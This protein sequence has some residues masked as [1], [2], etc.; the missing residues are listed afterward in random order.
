MKIEII[1]IHNINNFGSVF[2]TYGLY[3]YL[4]DQGHDTEVIDYN[5]PYFRH[6]NLKR[7]LGEL[8]FFQDYHVR[9]T[10]FNHF[11]KKNYKLSLKNYKTSKALQDHPPVADLYVAGG[12]QLWNPYHPCGNDDMYK[13][14]FTNGKKISYGTSMGKSSFSDNELCDLAFKI[15]DYFC[16]SVRESSSVSL[17]NKVGIQAHHVVDPV[18]LL[19]RAAYERYV[20][21][22]LI[23]GKYMFVYLV[24][25]SKLLEST[26]AYI[27]KKMGLKVVLCA[28]LSQKSTCDYMLRN[29]GPEEILSY[30]VNAEFIISASFH[31]T[32]FS[33]LYHK[34]FATLL[35]G[36][37]TN[38]RIEDFLSWNRLS[39]RIIKSGEDLNETLFSPVDFVFADK[40]IEAKRQYSLAYI[41]HALDTEDKKG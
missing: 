40:A 14:S 7:K 21:K 15:K 1:T 36:S 3:K 30:I 4:S 41:H 22:P 2:Q 26:I 38:E 31:A 17:L 6:S 33:V 8:L 35:P 19:P 37:N 28:G 13:M 32:L 29:A 9:K 39:D 24:T 12:D 20:S 18:L 34:Q 27:S 11:I 16:V 23:S 5:P 10:K 25:P